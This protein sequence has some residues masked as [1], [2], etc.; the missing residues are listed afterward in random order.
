[1]IACPHAHV[2]KPNNLLPNWEVGVE[3]QHVLWTNQV[4]NIIILYLFITWYEMYIMVKSHYIIMYVSGILRLCN[5][6]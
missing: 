3:Y 2:H 6:M 1:M 4:F 5:I